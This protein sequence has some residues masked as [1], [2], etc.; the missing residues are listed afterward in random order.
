MHKPGLIILAGALALAACGGNDAAPSLIMGGGVGSGDI[1]GKV[2]VYVIDQ[3]TF[4]PIAGAKVRVGTIDGMTDSTGLF[5]AKNDNLSGKQNVTAVASGHVPTMWVGVNGANVTIPVAVSGTGTP[6]VPQAE[7]DATIDGWASFNPLGQNDAVVGIVSYSQT[8]DLGAAENNIPQGAGPAQGITANMCL[9][10]ALGSPACA[11]KVNSRT[12]RVA[13]VA[14]IANINFNGTPQNQA[15]WVYTVLG[16]DAKTGLTVDNG[17]NQ[18][19]LELTQIAAGNTVTGS[20]DF[21]TP[22]AALTN[23]VGLI[24]LDL[25]QDGI[26]YVQDPL[27]PTAHTEL[28]PTAA[29]LPGLTYRVLVTAAVSSGSDT[30]SAILKHGLSD[31]TN[32]GVG[33]WL[34]TPTGM[35]ASGDTMTTAAVTGAKLYGF[36]VRDSSG[37]TVWS[38]TTFD[39]SLSVTLPTDLAPIPTGADTLKV[40]ALDATLDVQNFNLQNKLDLLNRLSS[41]TVTFTK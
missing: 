36:D 27:K 23:V 32:I 33:D 9:K 26:V 34:N 30:Q 6:T 11:P 15:N 38:A 2:N 20:I 21:G 28:V 25:G 1:D 40:N 31:A 24:G 35:S 14:T 13:L 22:P 10:S 19:G 17:V 29:G 18:T 37:I 3:D 41:D 4:A 16:Y 8:P 5:T 12:G 39:S 7:L